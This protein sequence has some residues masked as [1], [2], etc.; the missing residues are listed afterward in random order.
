MVSA[1]NKDGKL[2]LRKLCDKLIEHLNRFRGGNLF[3]IDISCQD[4]SVR[5]LF[6]RE[7][8]NPFKNIFLVLD[9][10][11]F[12]HSLSDMKI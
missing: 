12:I 1:D 7:I 2:S 5:H 4:H 3:I 10:R 11:K 9:H 6:L 8:Q